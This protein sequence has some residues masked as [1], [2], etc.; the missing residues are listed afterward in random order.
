M[1]DISVNV[2]G[3]F[4]KM[5]RFWAFFFVKHR[6]LYY[7]RFTHKNL[8]NNRL[9]KIKRILLLKRKRSRKADTCEGISLSLRSD[10][11]CCS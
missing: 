7:D 4:D 5:E 3:F 2:S 11:S 10:T 1:W 8:N 6:E 9:V